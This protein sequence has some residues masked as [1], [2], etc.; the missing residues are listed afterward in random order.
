MEMTNVSI[1]TTLNQFVNQ[2]GI[3]QPYPILGAMVNN[4]VKDLT[5]PIHKPSIIN[6][7]DIRS[8]HGISMYIASL[9]FVLYKAV[10][11]LYPEGELQ[12]IMPI[13][14]GRYCEIHKLSTSLTPDIILKIRSRM[15]EIISANMQI[16]KIEMPEKMAVESLYREHLDVQAELL[17]QRKTLYHTI[18]GLDNLYLYFPFNLVDF[19]G[20][21]HKF[22]LVPYEDGM[23]LQYPVFTHP[24]NIPVP[25]K[26]EKLFSVLKE[27]KSWVKLLEVPSIKDLNQKVEENTIKAFVRMS[28]AL[29]EK[30]LSQIA[31]AIHNKQTA[32]IVLLSGPSSS[33]KTTT[34]KR[35][36]VQLGVL[37]YKPIEISM[38]N[39]FVERENTPKDE[40]G[41]YDFEDLQALDLELFN[42]TLQNLLDGKEVEMPTFNFQLGKKEW[43]GH[44]LQMGEKSIL[45]IEGIHALNPRLIEN[46]DDKYKFKIFASALTPIAFDA[47]TPL[48]STDNRLLR[49]I[50]RDHK[51][52]GYTAL[53]TLKRWK[54]V[55][56]GENKN[57]LPY[58]GYADEMFNTALLCEF[59]V[60]KNAVEPILTEVPSN[61]PEYA[62]AQRLL[63]LL[64]FFKPIPL[65]EIP[66]LSILREF[67]GGSD[68]AY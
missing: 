62:D 61:E 33:G 56:Q 68:F 17:K 67:L 47:L 54:S 11:D 24:D 45:V 23:L 44:H 16:T 14:K 38:D 25:E 29:H 4:K 58:Q 22:D 30:R 66:S 20:V 34:C 19:T 60:I 15:A 1:G 39:F 21:L 55:R 36:S 13:S 63:K 43:H 5:Y 46:I 53:E 35:L 50:I 40:H 31:D 65:T 49:R 48:S 57:I 12:V 52:R 2:I 6:F 32:K 42:N 10:K 64:S 18:Y 28:E 41:D 3:E 27:Y 8:C 9:I 37:G 51:Y 26:Q 59:G 7:F